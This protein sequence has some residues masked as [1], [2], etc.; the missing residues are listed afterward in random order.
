MLRAD[1]SLE[2]GAGH[3][4]RCLAIAQAWRADG[5]DAAL[6][7]AELPESLER[8]FTDDGIA[9]EQVEGEIGSATDGLQTLE[10]AG[11]RQAKAIAID[12]YRF[13]LGYQNS[14]RQGFPLLVVDDFGQIGEWNCNWIL[15]QNLG[16]RFDRYR[17]DAGRPQLLLGS[18]YALL[19]KEFASFAG[20]ERSIPE[21]ANK[22][23][24]AFGGSGATTL[25]QK[26]IDAICRVAIDDLHVIVV[27]AN[28]DGLRIPISNAL[29]KPIRIEVQSNVA[30]MPRLLAWAD[31]AIG[32]GG[33]SSWER[34]FLGL[35]ALIVVL[36][37][38]QR[39]VAVACDREELCRNLGWHAD[40]DIEQLTDSIAELAQDA[41][42]RQSMATAGQALVDGDGAARVVMALRGESIRL[43]PAHAGDK[44]TFWELSN[45]PSVRAASFHSL[46]IP[47]EDHERWFANRLANADSRL[48]MAY[49]A[50]DRVVGQSRLDFEGGDAVIS[51]GVSE[52]S[53][54]LG[55]GKQIVSSTVRRAFATGRCNRIMAF[56]KPDNAAST[57]TFEK[58]GFTFDRAVTTAGQSANLLLL[59]QRSDGLLA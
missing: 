45:Q 42:A 34:A 58:A 41:N 38:N 35:P 10:I 49:D 20:F 28:A 5:G 37:E 13:G 52:S 25:L 7:S 56:I 6:A 48:L 55:Y 16:A 22:L 17:V 40:V 46:P 9:V 8:R 11:R 24:V 3:V 53:R 59:D 27:T 18:K 43:R 4:M 30:D 21:T 39:E 15:D 36:A 26:S 1:A 44:R 23:L 47:W 54:G 14:L 50:D 2:I 12:G 57:R 29:G 19:R 32:A 51:I 31:L 33:S